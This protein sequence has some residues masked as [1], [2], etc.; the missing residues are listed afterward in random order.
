VPKLFDDLVLCPD[1]DDVYRFNLLAGDRLTAAVTGTLPQARATV[2]LLD[3]DAET[4]V[5]FTETP[6]RGDGRLVYTAQ[7]DELVFLRVNAL[8]AQTPYDL[9]ALVTRASVCAAD[10]FEGGDGVN[11]DTI[12]TATQ[13]LLVPVG[14][15][16]QAEVC[17]DD[18]DFYAADLAPGEGLQAI[19]AFDR[20][21]AD[22]DVAIV[23]AAG[24]VLVNSAGIEQPEVVQ[25]RLQAGG[26][27]YVRVRGFGN[28][29][30]P[31]TL[32]L[33]RLAPVGC[34]D[35]LEPVSPAILDDTAPRT[36]V[37]P[38]VDSV[39]GGAAIVEERGLCTGGAL[40]DADRWAI[41]VEDFERLVVTSS[42]EPGLRLSLTIE[43][44]AG[45]V[46]ATSP[47]GVGGAAVSLDARAAETLF[48][49]A[50]SPG[51]Q[52]GAYTV[53]F[54]K[55]NQG[56]CPTDALEPNNTVATRSALPG[57]ADVVTICE[58]DEDFFVLPGTAGKKATIDVTFA[59]GDADID[60]QVLG[61]DGVQ[62]LATADSSSDNEHLEALL[63]IDGDYT[64]RVFSLSSGARARYFLSTTVE[65]PDP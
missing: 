52:L 43:D 36:I 48:V 23:D 37:V 15:P 1:D 22:L 29:N 51:G 35:A 27:V 21:R 40:P 17:P 25:R 61:L 44:G 62:I 49:R 11:N 56:G 39:V 32:T 45:V 9:D 47:I 14:V 38:N 24:G 10:F 16:L 19:L 59:H 5:A 57:P 6:P 2:W 20:A 55:E 13:P 41:A 60:V 33:L 46:L 8:L 12:A 4:S 63:P 26:R 7:Q 54:V 53:R 18:T 65:S 28:S 30:G 3:R 31:Y 64:V 42:A 34:S 58:S 50:R